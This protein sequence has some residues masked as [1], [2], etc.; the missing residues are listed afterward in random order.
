MRLLLAVFLVVSSHFFVPAAAAPVKPPAAKQASAAFTRDPALPKWVEGIEQV[1]QSTV[2][3]PVVIR[4]AEVH[5]WTGPNPAYLVNRAVQVNASSRLSEIGQFSIDFAPA[6]E[7]LILHRIAILRGDQVL[8]RTRSANVRVLDQETDAEKGYYHGAAV[9]QIL[10]EDVAPGDTLWLTYTVEGRNPVFG[11]AWFE[12]LPWTKASPIELRKL[13]VAYPTNRALQWRVS[14]ASRASLPP[15]AI[16]QKGPVTRMTFRERALAADELEPSMPPSL[17]P[18][19]FLDMTEYKDWAQVTRWA[20]SLFPN[21]SSHPEVQALAR[22]FDGKTAEERASQALHWVQD[23]IRY[24]SVS[25]GENS[26]RPQPPEVVLKRRFGDC[27]DKTQLLVALYRA[28]GLQAQPVLLNASFPKFPAQFLPSPRSFNHAIVRVILDGT[29]YFVDPTRHNEHG[30]ISKLPVAAAGAAVLVVD[31]ATLGLSNLPEEVVTVPLVERTERMKIAALHGEGQLSIRTEYRG[32][33]AAPM[34]DAY[35]GMGSFDL[36]KFLLSEVE[37]TYPGIQL[38]A[39]PV[40]SD[41]ADGTS[42]IV[43]AEMTIPAPLKEE[44]GRVTLPLRS[45]IIEGT[46]GIP[47]KLVRKHPLWLAAGRHRARYNLDVSLPGEARL[48]QQDDSFN[49]STSFIEAHAQ[50]TWR[51]AHLGYYLDYAIKNPE[52]AAAELPGLAEQ[53]QKLNPLF[54]NKLAFAPLAIPPQTA[55]DASLRVLDIMSKMWAYEDL[56]D[57]AMRTGKLPEIKLDDASYAK[58]NYRAM[59]ESIVDLYAVRKWNPIVAVPAAAL[60]KIVAAKSDK[61]SKQLCDARATLVEGDLAGASKMLAALGTPDDDQLTLMQAWAD[62]HAGNPAGARANLLRFLK[63]KR[64]SAT[65]L[66][67]RDALAGLALARRL[68]MDE[69]AEVAEARGALN[70][71]AWPMPLFRLLRG[72]IT[73]EDLLRT[74]GQLPPAAREYAELEAR[75]VISQAFLASHQPR[76]ADIHLNWLLRS[77]LSGS[78]IE[79]LANADR[80]GEALL[81]PDL[82]KADEWSDRPRGHEADISRSLQAAAAKGNALAE[83]RLGYLYLHGKGGLSRDVPKALTLLEAAAAQGFGDAMNVLGN[84]Y[85]DGNGV[86]RDDQRAIAYYRQAV[87]YGDLDAAHNLGYAYFFGQR[88]QPIDYAQAFQLFRQA[89]EMG[90]KNSQF[91]LSRMY[92]EGRGTEKNDT[93][94]RF[95]ATQAYFRN[96]VDGTAQLGLILLRSGTEKEIQEAGMRLLAAAASRQHAFALREYG[97]VLL[98]GINV[99]P[100]PESA[101]RLIEA[102]HQVGS[103]RATA[104]LGRMYVEGLGVKRDAAKGMALLNKVEQAGEADAYYQLGLLYR[105]DTSGMTDKAKAVQYFRLGAGRG[106]LEAAELYAVMLHTGEGC[107]PD[108]V[109][110]A[111]YYEMAVRAGKPRAM[112]NLADLYERGQ[113]VSKD[114]HHAADLYRKAAFLGSLPALWNLAELHEA[115]ADGTKPPFVSLAYYMLANRFGMHEA[116]SAVQRLKA[117]TDPATFEKAQ[118]FADGW[119]PG[120]ALPEEV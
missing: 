32:R 71:N 84:A 4:L 89:A 25:I 11:P 88:G 80:Y 63:G 86:P 69:P 91:F 120:K 23:D 102:A 60:Q 85:A 65:Q 50:L 118:K 37:R 106:Q 70:A 27:K 100:D 61:R 101:F 19:P 3:E 110:A 35:K 95:W 51:G 74:V 78:D 114:V 47:D 75:F 24:F 111:R 119:K 115:G 14:G 73:A 12:T 42:F 15:P 58:L 97:R 28:M 112:N 87:E 67:P 104:L 21:A 1:P 13:V 22:K 103:D 108:L 33:M 57:E 116:A 8:D 76:K 36:K 113:G 18:L 43:E 94:A 62:F 34:R 52:V 79:I 109:E 90:Q 68:G 40:L 6:Y 45:H 41:S 26:H 5:Y 16:E 72:E 96:D 92:F 107:A 29:P 99:K 98:E 20:L 44:N 81:D 55:K 117:R 82:R 93:L 9:A 46:L 83:Y 49:L 66:G 59:C 2:D 53:L 54:E 7:K 48:V 77:A 17:L 10:L 38:R 31:D 30:P 64:N 39:T 105:S 56:Q